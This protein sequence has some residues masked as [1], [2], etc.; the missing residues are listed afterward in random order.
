MDNVVSLS[1]ERTKR[2]VA[3]A[4]PA[5]EGER[6]AYYS[7]T[8]AREWRKFRGF[9]VKELAFRAGLP[10]MAIVRIER[11]R[12]VLLRLDTLRRLCS[13]L[14]ISQYDFINTDPPSGD[15]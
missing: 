3:V 13:A 14:G 10:P 12:P 5:D 4:P 9:T 2:A 15:A 8:N 11:D 1:A 7:G 6:S